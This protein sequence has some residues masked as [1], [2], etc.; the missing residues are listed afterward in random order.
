MKQTP[1]KIIIFDTTLRDG[2]QSP[3]ASMNI[4]EKVLVAKQLETLG[5][6]KLEAGFP[7]SSPGDFDAVKQ[8][9]AEVKTSLVVGLART[10]DEDIKRAWDAVKV[11]NRPGLHTFIAT[12]DIHLEHK[13]HMAKNQVL[14]TVEDAV[15]A[16]G[17]CCSSVE[18]S[19]EDATRS[20]KGFLVDVFNVAVAA[21]AD[22]I[23]I[24]DTVGYTTPQ[25]FFDLVSYIKTNVKAAQDIAISVHCHNDLGLATANSISAIL[26][27][28]TQVEC[29]INGIGERAGNASLEEVVM[30]LNVRK[31]IYNFYSGID[32]TQIYPASR[33]VSHITGISVQPNKAIVGANAFAHEAGIHQDGYLKE[34]TTYEIMTPES[35]GIGRSS[36]VLGKHSGKHALKN[37]LEALGYNLADTEISKVFK[38]FKNISDRKKDIYDEDIEAIVMEEIYRIPDKY[39]LKYLNVTSGTV[40]VPTA[41]VQL[42][43]EGEVVQTAGFGNGPVDA[44]YKTIIQM[45]GVD[46]KLLHFSVS[47][48]TGGTDALGEVT[49]DLQDKNRIAVGHGSDPDILVASGKA[50]VNAM[51]RLE[52]LKTRDLSV[53][54]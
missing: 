25:E 44:V 5:V 45:T 35:V 20:D 32:T 46:A 4:G 27:G 33:L 18:F 9:A 24:P 2:E 49:V 42:E 17:Q 28:A 30:A 54:K 31:D 37:R 14:K 1:K 13:L 26:A 40:A 7:A 23:N 53:D 29:T 6:D 51:N 47:S 39:R 22:T 34:R 36:L 16:C 38:R 12:S 21:G 3:G 10:R 15:K 41:T 50:M 11:A 48:I 8:V 19:A 52:F 43:I